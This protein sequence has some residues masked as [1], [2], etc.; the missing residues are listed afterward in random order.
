MPTSVKSNFLLNVIYS[1]SGILFHLITFPYVSRILMADGVGIVHFLQ[2][3]VNY[4]ALCSSLGI[5]LYAIR[6]IAR[7]RDNIEA[8]S[9]ITVE[10]LILHL[11]LTILGYLA[12]FVLL[13]YVDQIHAHFSLFLLL[14]IHLMLNALGAYWFYQGVENFKYIT[15]RAVTVRILAAIALFLLVKERSDLMSYAFVIV[16][17]EAGNNLFNFFRLKKYIDVKSLRISELRPLRHLKP[18]LKIFVLNLVISIYV[19]LDTVM[20]GFLKN[21][22]IVGYYAAATRITK[23]I[24]SIAQSLGGVLLPKFSNLAEIHHL[25]ELRLLADKSLRFVILLSLPLTVGVI[26]MASPLIHLFCG[27]N[28]DPSILTIQIMAPIIIFISI[29]NI[30]GPQILYA[31]GKEKLVIVS[32]FCGAI[33]NVSLNLLLIPRYSQYGA[34]F[35]TSVAEFWVLILMIVFCRKYIQIRIFTS[36]NM[37]YVIGSI[38]LLCWLMFLGGLGLNENVYCLVGIAS[39]VVIYTSYLIL[40]KDSFVVEMSYLL[41][42]HK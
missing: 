11:I 37:K 38:I 14:S 3:I 4:V 8:C 26:C 28:F 35:A 34:G 18:A 6:E 30:A 2:S 36:Q 16:A 31:L 1:L 23:S 19:N 41:R 21:E 9:R 33:I 42:R 20:L 17:A 12:I 40:T 7:V 24:L 29:S 32:T 39:S 10:I 25:D 22:T 27:N 13:C 15:I 5:P